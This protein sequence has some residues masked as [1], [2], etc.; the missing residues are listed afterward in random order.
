V[1]ARHYGDFDR[2]KLT[3][4]RSVSVLPVYV[5]YR[6]GDTIYWT[7]KRLRLKMG[8]LLLTDGTNFARG[9]CGNR[10][11]WSVQSPV[12]RSEPFPILLDNPVFPADQPPIPAEEIAAISP[13]AVPK[14]VPVPPRVV[15]AGGH[16]WLVPVIG[17]GVVGGVLAA[18]HGG[19]KRG[20]GKSGGG[21]GGGNN[22]PP[23]VVPE[24]SFVVPVL[25]GFAAIVAR[26]TY[27]RYHG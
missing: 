21:A 24:P 13:R 18:T 17:A 14:T 10:I 1:V 16:G 23:E 27:R 3:T 25:A 20:G 2:S 7:R 5:S 26:R 8:E 22:N 11:A 4:T 19:G 15:R 12:T 6:I 9:R